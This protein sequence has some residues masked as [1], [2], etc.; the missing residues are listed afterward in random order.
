MNPMRSRSIVLVLAAS[1]LA[2]TVT[3][4]KAPAAGTVPVLTAGNPALLQGFGGRGRGRGGVPD[5]TPGQLEAL[6]A[7]DVA[8][9]EVTASVTAARNAVAA[10]TFAEPANPAALAAAVDELR[11]A[12]LALATKRAE[13]FALIQA[14]PNRLS[15][16]QVEALVAAGGSVPAGRG[17][18]ARGGRGN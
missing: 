4:A 6:G 1:A 12:E 13:E 15:P 14:G 7:M 16:E 10:A 5:A 11:A 3:Y 9:T 18:G 17:G 2:F 8:L